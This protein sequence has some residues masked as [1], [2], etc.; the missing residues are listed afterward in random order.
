[1]G[2]ARRRR[3]WRRLTRELGAAGVGVSGIRTPQGAR[4]F[5]S[6][7]IVDATGERW[8]FPY[9]GEGLD[10]D[11]SR[12]PLREVAR[13]GAVLTDL[14]HPRL[15]SAVLE[16]A[17]RAGVPS[18]V[19]LGNLLHLEIGLQAD[20]VIAAE[21]AAHDLLRVSGVSPAPDDSS[22]WA[23]AALAVLRARD[24]QV[25]AVTLGEEGVIY[26]AGE[27]LRHLPALPVAVVDTTGAGDTFHGVWAAALARGET[28]DTCAQ[29]AT[30]AAAMA[31]QGPGRSTL[32]TGDE[33]RAL[34]QQRTLR[35][36]NDRAWA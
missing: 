32:A 12:W 17:R 13:Y 8:I 3:S 6:A 36:L 26:D 24:D 18:V 22:A 28:P 7:V 4:T 25:V 20:V 5:T 9:R 2:T 29:H 15:S 34:L 21:E 16:E 19:D 11:P 1:M 27:G 14:R 23:E 33:V 30:V 35:E 10:D 31:C